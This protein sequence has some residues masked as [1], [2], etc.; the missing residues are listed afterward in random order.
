MYSYDL[1]SRKGWYSKNLTVVLIIILK[2]NDKF[3]VLKGL[4]RYIKS[5]NYHINFSQEELN[6]IIAEVAALIMKI[7]KTEFFRFE[8]CRVLSYHKY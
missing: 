1:H 4:K 7:Q 8:G 2:I 5:N 6:L 3:A